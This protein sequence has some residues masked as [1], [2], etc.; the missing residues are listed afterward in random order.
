M[1]N[2]VSG[3]HVNRQPVQTRNACRRTGGRGQEGLLHAVGLEVE[4]LLNRSLVVDLH[5]RD[6]APNGNHGQSTVHYL[7]SL[8]LLVLGRVLAEAQRVEAERPRL[9]QAI[10][11]LLESVAADGLKNNNG[12]KDLQH[13]ASRD[14][15]VVGVNGKHLGEVR[16]AKCELLLDDHPEGSE[17]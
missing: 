2:C 4:E 3:I 1:T 7:I 11:S 13:A 5:L 17:L 16:P 15:V 6:H 10:N 14:V 12:H 8:V 9:P